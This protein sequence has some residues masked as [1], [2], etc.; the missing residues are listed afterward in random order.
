MRV[1]KVASQ[2]GASVSSRNPQAM[3]SSATQAGRFVRA[4]G[5]AVK[6]CELTLRGG[7]FLHPR[8]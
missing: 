4:K 1:V 7:L 8:R 6:I 3:L 2:I 5:G